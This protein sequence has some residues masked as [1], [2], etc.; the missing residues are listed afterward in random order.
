MRL[1]VLSIAFEGFEGV[2]LNGISR[3]PPAPARLLS[4]FCALLIVHRK[5]KKYGWLSA[6]AQKLSKGL[7][8]QDD[9][10]L[11]LWQYPS[12]LRVDY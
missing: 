1:S 10:S 7:I 5:S 12:E 6:L 4:A 11:A 2:S 8:C 9:A 3:P